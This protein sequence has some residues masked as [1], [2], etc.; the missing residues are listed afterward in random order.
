MLRTE[1]RRLSQ[2]RSHLRQDKAEFDKSVMHIE[3]NT[4]LYKE[5]IEKLKSE[6]YDLQKSV[7]ELKRRADDS[8]KKYFDLK[9]RLRQMEKIESQRA[10][11]KMAK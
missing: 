7:F 11:K 8:D 3:R 10:E 9:I 5:M 6:K 2:D 1:I 4:Q